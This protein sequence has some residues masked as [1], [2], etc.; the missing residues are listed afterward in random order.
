[1]KKL[2]FLFTLAFIALGIVSC[3]DDNDITPN[4]G[5]VPIE[6][7]VAT[8]P[9]DL[10]QRADWIF[11]VSDGFTYN[12][13]GKLPGYEYQYTVDGN[14][15]TATPKSE[16]EISNLRF[17]TGI[18]PDI[19][20]PSTEISFRSPQYP[21]NFGKDLEDGALIDQSTKEQF[22]THDLLF[23]Y[24][25]QSTTEGLGNL[26]L[27]HKHTLV[28]LT[29]PETT[30]AIKVTIVGKTSFD[31]T[32][33]WKPYKTDVSTYRAIVIGDYMSTYSVLIE[34]GD[35]T[36]EVVLSQWQDNSLMHDVHYTY[37]L[38]IKG[39][40]YKITNVEQKEWSKNKWTVE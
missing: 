39:D 14:K 28:E 5:V 15:I 3:D 16:K 24:Y 40:E 4:E 17:C 34:Q 37:N 7:V 21:T 12:T 2:I 10:E 6:K 18:C 26:Q 31:K 32:Y 19:A 13:D 35:K 29:L 38:E 25:Y 27:E 36:Y 23:Y 1:M 22:L 30:E 9:V 33:T 11:F 8:A 20:I